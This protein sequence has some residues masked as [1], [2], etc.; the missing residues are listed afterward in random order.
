MWSLVLLPCLSRRRARL[1]SWPAVRR[2][3]RP[4]RSRCIGTLC[5][6]TLRQ[7]CV[8]HAAAGPPDPSPQPP[9]AHGLLAPR[10]LC[11]AGLR[12]PARECRCASFQSHRSMSCSGSA[13]TMRKSVRASTRPSR[14]RAGTCSRCV[15]RSRAWSRP[16]Q[17]ACWLQTDQIAVCRLFLLFCRNLE[18]EQAT[19][20][21]VSL[22]RVR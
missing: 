1:R 8:L 11:V 10:R 19:E 12:F 6:S 20:K 5:G 3:T 22:K 16:S 4:S 7:H 13:T 14:W 15:A 21:V 17:T 2:P 18:I 9:H